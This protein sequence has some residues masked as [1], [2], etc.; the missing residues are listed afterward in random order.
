M[1]IQLPTLILKHELENLQQTC[2]KV[3]S[4]NTLWII[5]EGL[6][7]PSFALLHVVFYAFH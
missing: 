4:L 6:K 7:E 5:E 1:T 3:F 2:Q